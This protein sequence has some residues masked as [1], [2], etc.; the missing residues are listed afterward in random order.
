MILPLPLAPFDEYMLQDDRPAYPMSS[1]ARLRFSGRMDR[2][3]ATAAFAT[4]VGRHPLLS[5]IVRRSGRRFDFVPAEFP[6]SRFQWSAAPG[7]GSF[8]ATRGLDLFSEPG[9][10]AWGLEEPSGSTLVLQFHHACCDGLAVLQFIED[11]L[12]SYAMAVGGDA[13]GAS[14]PA[15]LRPLDARRLR[16]RWAFGLSA[17]KLLALLTRQMI[18]LLGVGQ[19]L[20]RRPVSLMAQHNPAAA[21]ALPPNYPTVVTRRLGPDETRTLG[22]AAA[23]EGV[24]VNDRLI[25]DL[26][27]AVADFRSRHEPQ[28]KPGWLRFSVPM[29]LRTPEDDQMPAANVVSMIFLDRRGP[30]LADRGRLLTGIHD[31][32]QLIKRNRLGLTFIACLYAFRMLPHG[33]ARMTQ[34]DGSLATCLIS[35]LGNF[36]SRIPLP[37]RA[38]RIAAGNLLLEHLDIMPPLRQGMAAAF[39]AFFYA[40]A[41]CVSLHYDARRLTPAQ[42][43]DLLDTFIEQLRS[44]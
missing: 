15:A 9:L 27:L 44:P 8:P 32:L 41:L 3:A 35:N 2:K 28:A 20:L 31:E 29:N 14:R 1:F 42:A 5:A 21:A 26:F 6:S 39:V 10:R 23:R 37:N 22:A 13:D 30:A 24:T 43:A 34:G 11:F 38:G 33:L 36:L 19:F 17:A 7:D 16:R 18:G 40:G 25:R 4:T 12:V